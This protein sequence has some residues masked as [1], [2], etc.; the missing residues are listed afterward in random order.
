VALTA[1]AAYDAPSADEAQKSQVEA[2]V[3]EAIQ[4]HHEESNLLPKLAMIRLRQGRY[5]EAETLLHQA[6]TSNPDNPEARNNLAWLLSHRDPS[7]SKTQEALELIDRAI[8]V[9]GENATLLDTR[10]EIYLELGQTNRAL[11]DLGRALKLKPSGRASYFHLAR[12]HWMAQNKVESRTAF[13]RAVEL[14]LTPETVDPLERASYLQ[15]R[16]DLGLR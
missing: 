7:P 6:L 3:V 4:K 5:D 2:W 1:L 14:G 13:Q 11:Q 10:A 8:E 12:A 15:L 9:A 16:Q